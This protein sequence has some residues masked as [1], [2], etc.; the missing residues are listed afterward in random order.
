MKSGRV[1]QHG[2]GAQRAASSALPGFP[3]ADMVIDDFSGSEKPET[4]LKVRGGGA[5]F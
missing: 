3:P 5:F 2:L 4:N 1:R